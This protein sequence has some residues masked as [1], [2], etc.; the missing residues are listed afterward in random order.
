MITLRRRLLHR[1]ARGMGS[2]VP[3]DSVF[4]LDSGP[5]PFLSIHVCRNQRTGGLA[6]TEAENDLLALV[7]PG[8]PG[9]PVH[10]GTADQW[11]CRP[12]GRGCWP[13]GRAS[14]GCGSPASFTGRE[15]EALSRSHRCLATL[16]TTG[17]TLATPQGFPYLLFPERA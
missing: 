15:T 9:W 16:N 1:P 10:L 14:G 4:P 6:I 12:P 17:S 2:V 5:F 8:W 7:V 13:P 3:A 11:T